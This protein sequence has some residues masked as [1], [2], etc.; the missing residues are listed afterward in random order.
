M[1]S[2]SRCRFIPHANVLILLGLVVVFALASVP[3]EHRNISVLVDLELQHKS[4]VELFWN[5]FQ[6]E[7]YRTTH[8]GAGRTLIKLDLP[9]IQI[10]QLRIDPTERADEDISIRRIA[11]SLPDGT[12]HEIPLD[13]I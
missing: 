4:A 9:N 7:P 2:H 6:D 1:M 12:Q 8:P 3:N 10:Y 5:K 13:R 11:V